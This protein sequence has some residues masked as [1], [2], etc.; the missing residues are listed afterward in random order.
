MPLS[1]GGVYAAHISPT[2]KRG[3]A[4]AGMA[5]DL[6]LQVDVNRNSSF[7]A[8]RANVNRSLPQIDR[9]H[10]DGELDASG[11]SS[12]SPGAPQ[13]LQVPTAGAES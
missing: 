13:L 10:V 12:E 11:R 7:A 3:K 8:R 6:D 2:R 5:R 4:S 9:V 1:G